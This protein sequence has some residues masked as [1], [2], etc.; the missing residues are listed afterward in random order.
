MKPFNFEFTEDMAHIPYKP[1]LCFLRLYASKGRL[2]TREQLLDFAWEDNLEVEE[3][4]VDTAIKRLRRMMPD[5]KI[6]TM[7]GLG[8]VMSTEQ[9]WP[10]MKITDTCDCC[11]Q[12]IAVE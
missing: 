12:S 8:Y 4:N 1:L 7:Y 6:K 10:F 5:V 3:R 9:E 11:G 2:V